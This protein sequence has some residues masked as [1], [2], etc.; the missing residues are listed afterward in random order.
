MQ[1]I[2]EVIT[3]TKILKWACFS[4][5]GG[6]LFLVLN[7]FTYIGIPLFLLGLFT[8]MYASEKCSL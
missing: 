7:A 1:K 2:E 6:V 8:V 5:L 3:P 4:L